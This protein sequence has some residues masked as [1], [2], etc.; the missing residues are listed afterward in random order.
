MESKWNPQSRVQYKRG[1]QDTSWRN[2]SEQEL[3][4][5]IKEMDMRKFGRDVCKYWPKM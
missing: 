2:C 1:N 4:D 3:Q 5:R